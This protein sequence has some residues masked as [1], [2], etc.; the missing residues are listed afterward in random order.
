MVIPEGAYN[1]RLIQQPHSDELSLGVVPGTIGAQVAE[2]ALQ[3]AM[4]DR[5]DA[6]EP[7]TIN[8]RS[9]RGQA[10]RLRRA[11]HAVPSDP[12]VLRQEVV[13][14]GE[15]A[16]ALLEGL[17]SL[18]V[19][20]AEHS[21]HVEDFPASQREPYLP[22]LSHDQQVGAQADAV[23]GELLD[24]ASILA[25]ENQAPRRNPAQLS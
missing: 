9:L 11:N 2:L 13:V 21:A 17:G 12:S 22:A 24:Q 5:V 18:T 3:A 8:L 10:L 23:M 6:T 25:G 19:R 15:A 7:R 1:I 16:E 20:A 4:D 14:R